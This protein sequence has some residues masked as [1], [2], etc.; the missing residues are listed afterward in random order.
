MIC[1]H[2]MVL[3]ENPYDGQDYKEWGV[4]EIGTVTDLTA[5]TVCEHACTCSKTGM[6]ELVSYATAYGP[7]P[8]D[9]QHSCQL[10]T[11]CA[12]ASSLSLAAVMASVG[13]FTLCYRI[14]P[15]MLHFL[16]SY[17][18][19]SFET[20]PQISWLLTLMSLKNSCWCPFFLQVKNVHILSILS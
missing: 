13:L 9:I 2:L 7:L 4:R 16:V 11:G 1:S 20:F 15:Q 8:V 3:I 14:Y 17:L 18:V 5:G 10:S 19:S 6:W 12:A